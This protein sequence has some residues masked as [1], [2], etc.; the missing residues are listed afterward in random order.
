MEDGRIRVLVH[1]SYD[2]TIL[3]S[4]QVLNGTRD[5][6]GD[7]ELGRDN[8]SGLADLQTIVGVATINGRPGSADRGAHAVCQGRHEGFEVLLRTEAAASRYHTGAGAEVGAVCLNEILA[9]PG[10]GSSQ[11]AFSCNVNGPG[12]GS[13]TI[14]GGEGRGTDS[15][16]FDGLGGLEGRNR[17]ASVDGARE[18]WKTRHS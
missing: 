16:E 6:D 11:R 13:L 14:R 8:C 3:H 17:I 4:R 12:F 15:E 9:S 1:C 5:P 2:L 10:A 18:S 7:V